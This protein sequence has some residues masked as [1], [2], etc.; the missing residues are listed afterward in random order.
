LLVNDT[1]LPDVFFKK[2]RLLPAFSASSRFQYQVFA[3]CYPW[4]VGRPR[5]LAA[6]PPWLAARLPK[7]PVWSRL[8]INSIKVGYSALLFSSIILFF[9]A[10]PVVRKNKIIQQL[11]LLVLLSS[12]TFWFHATQVAWMKKFMQTLVW[13]IVHQKSLSFF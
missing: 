5:V 12:K 2:I 13:S 4:L 6:K 9:H 10:T 7:F 11:L 8:F 3:E 1:S